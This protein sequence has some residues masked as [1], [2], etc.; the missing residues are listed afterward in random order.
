MNFEKKDLDFLIKWQRF[1]GL[2][3]QPLQ[4]FIQTQK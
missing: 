3:R 2:I 4:A 1:V